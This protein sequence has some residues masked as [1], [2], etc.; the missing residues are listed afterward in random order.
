MSKN[1][2]LILTRN[3]ELGKCKT[4]LAAKVGNR[5]ALDI[6]KFLLDKTV[7][8]TKDL[9]VEKWVYYSEEIWKDDIWDNKVYQ[10]KLQSG[11]DLGARMMNAFKEGFQAGFEH[12]IIIGSDMFHL[13]QSDMEEAFSQ[14]K[15]HNFV[16]G[17]AEDG[18]YYLLGMK[19]LKKELFQ[20]KDWGTNTVLG[21]TLSDIKNEKVSLLSEKND[22]DHY[23]DIKDIEA[24]APF[25]K[26][27]KE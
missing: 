3:P 24:F 20:N 26:H 19:S 13:N 6:Y 21:D 17:P 9:K 14:L 23:E 7:S 27:I 25:L 8:F 12:I 1:L 22:V 16:V 18:G 5:T 10:K 11:S 2:L 4:R 15:D